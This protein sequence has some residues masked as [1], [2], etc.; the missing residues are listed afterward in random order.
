MS[1]LEQLLEP[2]VQLV[3][4]TT[5][6]WWRGIAHA[7]PCVAT[8]RDS[9]DGKEKQSWEV[10]RRHPT[11][12]IELYTDRQYSTIIGNLPLQKAVSAALLP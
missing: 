7:R 1:P 4:V 12:S 2:S 11:K 5:S 8:G 3:R 6:S 10:G 9:R